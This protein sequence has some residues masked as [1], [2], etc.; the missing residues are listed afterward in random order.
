[1]AKNRTS[2]KKGDKRINKKGRPQGALSLTTKVRT[3]LEAI[4]EGR[5]VT[6]QELLVKRIL[7]KAIVD[8]NDQMIKLIWN[9]MDGMPKQ[10]IGFGDEGIDEIEIKIIR[11]DPTKEQRK[12]EKEDGINSSVRE[13]LGS[14]PKQGT[15]DNNK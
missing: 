9:Y 13:K 5:A 6:Y 1:M 12:K 4:A 7:K 11:N 15:Q 3:A 2:F 8:G 14:V 10:D